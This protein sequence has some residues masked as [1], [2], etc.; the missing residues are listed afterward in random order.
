MTSPRK[1]ALVY[2]ELFM[3]HDTQRYNMLTAPG[4]TVQ[5]GKHVENEETKRRMR[6]LIA[7]SQLEDFLVHL[8]PRPATR[9]ELMRF[10]TAA[11]IDRLEGLCEAGG[12]LAGP[13]TPVG[14]ASVDIAKLAVGGVLNA[15]DAVIAGDVDNAYVLCRP[16]GHHAEQEK[17][18]GFCLFANGVLGVL[19]AQQVHGLGRIAVVDWDVHH[20][21][22]AET[23]FYG[24]PEV[25]TISLHQDNLFPPQRGTAAE[26]GVG[27]GTGSNL[28]I[29]LPPGSGSGAYRAA[30]EE[31]VVPK[32]DAFRPEMIFVAS[33]FDAAAMDPLG[34]MMLSASDF[35]YMA[36]R[37]LEV[38]DRHSNG[39]IVMTHEGGYSEGYV[40]YCGL[41]VMEALSGRESGIEDPFASYISGYGWQAL[42]EHQ[43][44]A[45]QQAKAYHN[46]LKE[47]A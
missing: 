40:P 19:H 32:L 13:K 38:A 36:D 15:V 25:L 1:T 4:L 46:E 28:N 35:R 18:H 33:G 43:N 6:N 30:F 39:R 26:T 5:P 22:G 27:E 20:G 31:V 42:A 44:H 21:N 8:K 45:I 3:W 16:P 9:D 23:A 29:P 34:H 2:S 37:L 14:S 17:A 24:Q 12:G 11:H 7:V 47:L 41:A 10:H